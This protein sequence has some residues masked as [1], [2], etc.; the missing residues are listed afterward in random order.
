M[1][2]HMLHVCHGLPTALGMNNT[3]LSDAMPSPDVLL[4]DEHA[5]MMDG[6][7]QALLEHLQA[8]GDA[9]CM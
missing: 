2:R 5:C 4:A 9:A 1:A 6:L 7:G 3:G 8:E